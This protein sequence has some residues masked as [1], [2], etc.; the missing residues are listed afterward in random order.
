MKYSFGIVLLLAFAVIVSSTYAQ[1]EKETT[2][3]TV[4]ISTPTVQCDM[5]KDR[6]EKNLGEI[7]GIEKV[8]VNHQEKFAE[9]VFDTEK[10]DIDDV[11][12]K[13]ADIGYQADDIKAN[14]RAYR[15]LPNCC[16]V[17]DDRK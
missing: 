13:I 2:A 7:E 12:E 5:C 11:R 15:K 6:I 17:P 9:V 4:K 16:K 10:L 8:S 14:K 3:K 1:E